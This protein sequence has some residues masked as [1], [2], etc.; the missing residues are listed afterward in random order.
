MVRLTPT[1][2]QVDRYWR[3]VTF[4]LLLTDEERELLWSVAFSARN[5]HR[6]PRWSRLAQR[7]HCDR[8]TVKRRYLR[9]IVRLA[10]L[11]GRR[12]QG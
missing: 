5:R 8:R 2:P 3:A 6:G 7:Y 1:A 4:G 12:G 10:G 11:V 9:A